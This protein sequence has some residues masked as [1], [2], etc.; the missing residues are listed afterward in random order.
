MLATTGSPRG[1]TRSRAHAR[2][3]VSSMTSRSG[4]RWRML[5]VNG[6]EQEG[7]A[8]V[9]EQQGLARR[10][11]GCP[12]S[13][14]GVRL[15][16]LAQAR[17]R[18]RGRAT[19]SGVRSRA[20]SMRASPSYPTTSPSL[21]RTMGWTPPALTH[22][23]RRSAT[24]ASLSC[25][26]V[27]AAPASTIGLS[28]RESPRTSAEFSDRSLFA[29]TVSATA[30]RGDEP[31]AC[32]PTRDHRHDDRVPDARH[33]SGVRVPQG[34]AQDAESKSPRS[35]RSTCSRTSRPSSTRTVNR[36]GRR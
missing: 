6:C 9:D 12:Q 30:D 1:V 3:S 4:R 26:R 19:Q 2:C 34:A 31:W 14:R 11:P 32:R 35:R 18:R 5:I 20:A 23:T 8:G 25:N 15:E 13:P 22:R 16:L 10:R 21:R 7:H 33:R 28:A 36:P 27:V 24:S 29:F 17:P